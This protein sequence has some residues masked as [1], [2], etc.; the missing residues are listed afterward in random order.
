MT[1]AQPDTS[2]S[3]HRS[4]KTRSPPASMAT[5]STSTA[6]PGHS[7]RHSGVAS[8]FD[9]GDAK[10]PVGRQFWNPADDSKSRSEPKGRSE[11]KSHSARPKH[12]TSRRSKIGN[13]NSASAG[14]FP[15][16]LVHPPDMTTIPGWKLDRQPHTKPISYEKLVKLDSKQLQNLIGL[17]RTLLN[18]HDDFFLASSSP[19]ATPSVRHLPKKNNMPGRMWR[20]GIQSFLELLRKRLPGSREHMLTFLAVAY[21]I[22]TLQHETIPE[23]A[24]SWLECLGDLARYRMAIEDDAFEREIWTSASRSWYSTGSERLPE[25]GR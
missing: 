17:H 9:R 6:T 3:S 5:T 24:G 12:S 8:D 23:F 2:T 18:E 22:M 11:S 13:R 21:G 20:Y 14:L 4:K 16:P 7:H 19:S 15:V 1:S 10:N 25:V